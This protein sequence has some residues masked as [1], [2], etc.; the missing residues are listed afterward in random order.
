MTSTTAVEADHGRTLVG[1]TFEDGA[2]FVRFERRTDH[3]VVAWSAGC[4]AIGGTV[5]INETT[6]DVGGDLAS[7]AA[8][9][10]PEASAA[11]D[12][13]TAFMTSNPGWSLSDGRLTLRSGS[14]TREF[15]DAT[16][17]R[18]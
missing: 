7:S 10:T 12:A 6:L 16:R 3:D 2:A 14:Q 9:C 11:D 5:I 17:I 13:L 15:V 18:S 8:G 4:N 1:R